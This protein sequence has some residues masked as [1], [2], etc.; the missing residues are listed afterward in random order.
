MTAAGEYRYC[1]P[2]GGEFWSTVTACPDCGTLTVSYPPAV[3]V[4]ELSSTAERSPE[5]IMEFDLASLSATERRSLGPWLERE[6]IAH[7]WRDGVWLQ[8]GARHVD[9]AAEI[10]EHLPP[11]DDPVDPTARPAELLDKVFGAGDGAA[12][13][14]TGASNRVSTVSML[15]MTIDWLRS[16]FRR[17]R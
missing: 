6:G 14:A 16:K 15:T 11:A 5:E 2:C 17:Q 7:S 9:E 3:D 12:P 1:H 8:V 13:L 10:I 4:A